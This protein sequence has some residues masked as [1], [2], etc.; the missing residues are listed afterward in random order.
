MSIGAKLHRNLTIM[1]TSTLLG[2]LLALATF[3]SEA[4]P[5]SAYRGML[6][7][8]NNCHY[9]HYRFLHYRPRHK[10]RSMADLQHQIA[11]WQAE[12]GLDWDADDVADVQRYLNR[13]Y[14][15]FPDTGP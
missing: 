11:I 15:G 3:G 10:V 12:I 14:Y 9:C 8:E 13:L 1:K 2:I 6:L 4:R 5:P 7:Y